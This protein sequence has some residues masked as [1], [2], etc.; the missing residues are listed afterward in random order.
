MIKHCFKC[1]VCDKKI[2][3]ISDVSKHFEKFGHEKY[4]KRFSNIIVKLG[5]FHLELDTLRS[6]ISLIW[7][8]DCSYT[9]N[10]I[11]FKSPK[12]QIFQQKV[13]DL[14]KSFDTFS[15]T[16]KAK[17][18]EYVRPFVIYCLENKIEAISRSFDDW[19]TT[20]VQDESY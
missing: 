6:V 8:S 3:S 2:S 15:A 4:I 1:N 19:V 14:H 12:A 5:G 9:V 17:C 13:Q 20:D 7:K 10:S 11:G 16:R 18:L